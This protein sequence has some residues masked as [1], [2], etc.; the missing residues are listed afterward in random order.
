MPELLI[1]TNAAKVNRNLAG[2]GKKIWQAGKRSLSETTLQVQKAERIEINREFTVRKA[3]FNRNR[4]KIFKFPKASIDGMKA[5]IG[6]DSK[7]RG[8]PLLLQV[9]EEGGQKLPVE[10]SRVAIPLT[11]AK[12]RPSFRQGVAPSLRLDRLALHS[13]LSDRKV[14]GDKR[15]FILPTKRGE[16][17]LFQRGPGGRA[18]GDDPNMSPLYIFRNRVSLKKRLKFLAVATA[19]AE[20]QLPKLFNRYLL[21]YIKK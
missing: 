3:S 20:E 7:V 2:Y 5:I 4:V 13:R 15:T 1:T 11:G 18:T 16:Y 9:F 19:L 17:A 10:G 21:L 6:I 12:A 14:I 8:S